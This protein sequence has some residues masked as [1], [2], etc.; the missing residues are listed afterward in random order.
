[1]TR[2]CKTMSTTREHHKLRIRRMEKNV[3]AVG[4]LIARFHGRMTLAELYTA[5]IGHLALVNGEDLTIS[6]L[7][8]RSNQN[9]QSV[10][11]W[12]DKTPNVDL[13]DHPE[14]GRSKLIRAV[15]LARMVAYV[16]TMIAD[17]WLKEAAEQ[18]S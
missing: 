14:D 7:A 2:H 8:G 18:A 6:E 9:R 5:L 4:K 13:V 10:S 3:N 1:M 15:D 16:D 11:R 12:V 17:N